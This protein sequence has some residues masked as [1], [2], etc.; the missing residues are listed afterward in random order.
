MNPSGPTFLPAPLVATGAQ[1]QCSA[2]PTQQFKR[3]FEVGNKT[4]SAAVQIGHALAKNVLE[5]ASVGASP[6]NRKPEL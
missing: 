5:G 4:L 2:R 1:I 6:R 3:D